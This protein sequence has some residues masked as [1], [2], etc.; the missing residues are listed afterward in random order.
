MISKKAVIVFGEVLF[1][2]FNSGEEILGG[3]P[4]N[5]AWHLQ[6]FGDNPQFISRLGQDGAWDHSKSRLMRRTQQ[7]VLTSTLLM[8]NRITI[9]CRIWRMTLSSPLI[10]SL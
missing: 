2:R 10:V 6:A 7:A 4:F 8:T 9:L 1:D 3:A 5:V